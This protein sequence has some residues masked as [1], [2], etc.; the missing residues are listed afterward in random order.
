M[1]DITIISAELAFLIQRFLAFHRSPIPAENI[2]TNHGVNS[3]CVSHHNVIGGRGG[4][5][6]RWVG[7]NF[8]FS[9]GVQIISRIIFLYRREGG[10][11]LR[12]IINAVGSGGGGG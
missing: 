11:E 8:R 5:V 4:G 3:S 6:S 1:K 7:N 12:Y 2:C 10:G 9:I